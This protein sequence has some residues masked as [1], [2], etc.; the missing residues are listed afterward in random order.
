MNIKQVRALEILD[1]RGN[2]T[3]KAV[4]VLE[5]GSV[6][7]AMVPSG[8]STGS[9]EVTEL[10][11]N[12]PKRFL[13]QGVLKAVDNVSRLSGLLAGTDAADQGNVDRIMSEAD[14]TENKSRFG[15]NAIL[16]VSLSVARAEA[17]AE[18]QPLY[19]YLSRFNPYFSGR[20]TIPV[21]QM[22]IINGGKHASWSTDIQE[23][24]IIPAA[25]SRF[26]D[27]LRIGSEIYHELGTIIRSSGFVVSVGDE[28]GFA[29][30]AI[31]NRDPFEIMLRAI[32]TAGYEPGKDVFLAIDPAASA[33]YRD[34]VYE[35]QRENRKLRTSELE[36]Y[37]LNLLKTYPIRSV[38]YPFSEDDMEGFA[39]LTAKAGKDTQIVGDD[40]YTT[41]T[42][43]LAAGIDRHA[44][45]AVLIKPNQIGTLSETVETILLARKNGLACIMSHRSGETE[46]AFIADLSVAMGIGQ[47]KSG[48]PCRSERVAK[49]NRLIQIEWELGEQASYAQFPYST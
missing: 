29:M 39:S 46:D 13:G 42:K 35:L 16:A 6:G 48:A 28:G 47:I 30:Q 27:A 49:Y 21:P 8:A 26:A 33:F 20:F 15:G 18:K 43:R 37:Y 41:N 19:R 3:V 23:Y 36:A 44:T 40:L 4:T 25:V 14:G 32:N 10:R 1:S 38:E 17:A 9:H 45:N 24:M 22:N 7:E 34:G 5:D 11:D 2:P 31:S 12:D